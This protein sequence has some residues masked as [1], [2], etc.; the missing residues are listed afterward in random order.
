MCLEKNPY[1]WEEK[2]LQCSHVREYGASPESEKEAPEPVCED[3][4]AGFSTT[5][6][7]GYDKALEIFLYS[8]SSS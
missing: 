8:K 5:D 7:D 4:G 2:C 1:G 3:S 6:R